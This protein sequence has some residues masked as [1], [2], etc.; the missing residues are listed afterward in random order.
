MK[1]KRLERLG[2]PQIAGLAAVLSECV[3]AG[4]SVSFMLP[5]SQEKAAD[6]CAALPVRSSGA[7][8]WSSQP[9]QGRRRSWAR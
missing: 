4:A 7:S 5:M 3:Q 2:E 6:Y 8:A 9:S 1:I